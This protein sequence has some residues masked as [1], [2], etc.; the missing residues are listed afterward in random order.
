VNMAGWRAYFPTLSKA[1]PMTRVRSVR[2]LFAALTLTVGLGGA[3][4]A[5]DAM[6]LP[7]ARRST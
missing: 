1:G 6:G 4:L 7:H 3:A 2:C 5:A